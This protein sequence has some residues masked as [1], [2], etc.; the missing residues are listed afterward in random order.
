LIERISEP[1]LGMMPPEK[2]KLWDNNGVMGRVL[3]PLEDTYLEFI[4]DTKDIPRFEDV[5]VVT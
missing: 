1:Y 2:E 4:K 5:R 3:G